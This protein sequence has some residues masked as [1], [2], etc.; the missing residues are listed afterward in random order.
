[1]LEVQQGKQKCTPKG[2]EQLR[3]KAICIARLCWS[4]LKA[5]RLEAMV[6]AGDPGICSIQHFSG[7]PQH[8]H[9]QQRLQVDKC[10]FSK[11][12]PFLLL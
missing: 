7:D 9:C 12:F 5:N 6:S 8:T 4:P 10:W 1:M 2:N 3:Y 11:L